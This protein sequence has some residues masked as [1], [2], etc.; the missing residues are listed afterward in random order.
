MK[1]LVAPYE[2][3]AQMAYLARSGA[4]HAVITEDSDL[5]AY[6]CPRWGGL[7]A[8]SLAAPNTAERAAAPCH[9]TRQ[10]QAWVVMRSG[11]LPHPGCRVLFKLD[12]TGM[13]EQILLQDLP[14]NKG[15][16][17]AGFTHDMFLQVGAA[18][19]GVTGQRGWLSCCCSGEVLRAAHLQ[20]RGHP[21]CTVGHQGC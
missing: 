18:S 9:A 10:P 11:A 12:R 8:R 7:L 2:A 5:V 1:Y 13:G 21:A 16:S 6:A 3:D 15:L 17:L 19:Y 14:A 20:R 4:V